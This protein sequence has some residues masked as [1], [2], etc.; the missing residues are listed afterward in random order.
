MGTVSITE[1]TRVAKEVGHI[2]T[3]LDHNATVAVRASGE[4]MG[5]DQVTAF[6]LG[7]VCTQKSMRRGP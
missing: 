2:A 7:H 3:F 4:F 1:P 6:V 5:N